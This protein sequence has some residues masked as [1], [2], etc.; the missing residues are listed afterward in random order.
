MFQLKLRC[1][2]LIIIIIGWDTTHQLELLTGIF[3]SGYVNF[4]SSE[5]HEIWTLVTWY[6]N[7]V[8]WQC[9]IASLQSS[10]FQIVLYCFVS[11]VSWLQSLGFHTQPHHGIL[12]CN[13]CRMWCCSA[14]KV[15]LLAIYEIFSVLCNWYNYCV[16]FILI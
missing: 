5:S 7:P 12:L 1:P 6:R 13:F 11:N 3:P 16:S 2:C 8:L 10:I 14:S 15:N 9:A 4:W